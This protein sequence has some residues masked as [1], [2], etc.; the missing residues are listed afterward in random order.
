MSN[1]VVNKNGLDQVTLEMMTTGRNEATVNLQEAL[2]DE[3][4]DY[5]FCVDHLNVPLNSVP[6]TS[7]IDTELFR[8]IRRNVGESLN[9]E[10]TGANT[11]ARSI[12]LT[13]AL[14]VYTLQEKFYDVPTFVRSLNAWARG[15]EQTITLAGQIDFRQLGGP[16]GGTQAASVVEP[17]RELAQRSAAE[18]AQDGAY[19]FIRF[20][21][22]VDGTLLL[23]LT[24]DFTNNFLF[25]FSRFG[26]EILG[27]G[28]VVET[29]QRAI[30]TTNPVAG[31]ADIVGPVVDNYFLA[32]T[33]VNNVFSFSADDFLAGNL[34]TIVLGGNRS[35]VT[36]YSEHSLYMC[37]DQRVKISVTS[38][39]PMQNNMLV[40]EGIQTVDR[41]I[42][43]VYFDN[44]ITTSVAF[45]DEGVFKEQIITNTL[46]AGQFP[47]IK[48]SDRSKQ[49]HKLLTSYDLR[50]L[51]F[52]VNLTYRNYDSEKDEWRL[53]TDRLTIDPKRYWDFS[54]RFISEV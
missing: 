30:I 20:K 50:F 45:D 35:D 42:V 4:L 18:M 43:E 41:N 8:V 13:G 27:L 47:F 15:V 28:G 39:L 6:I 26:A 23:I 29:V 48:K 40:R 14:Y 12:L 36:I 54:L 46:Y 31:G 3:K 24:H 32:V 19:D 2:L 44:K 34:N 1:F 38:H 10:T 25:Q 37:L 5:V 11:T 16:S 51:R 33:S 17:L 21:L 52:H 22:A 7:A 53:K 9:N 49:W